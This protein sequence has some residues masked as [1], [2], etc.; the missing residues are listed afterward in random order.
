MMRFLL[1]GFVIAHGLVTAVIWVT[2]AKVG[3]PFR[4]THSWLLGDARRL[5]L[6]LALVAAAGFVLAGFGY[7]AEQGWWEVF[8]IGAGSVALMLMALY[9]NPWLLAGIAISSGVLYAGVQAL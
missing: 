6:V 8:A 5:A 7:L 9:F 4:A 1:G 2:P 3:E